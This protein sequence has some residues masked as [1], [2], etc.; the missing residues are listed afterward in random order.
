MEH[1]ARRVALEIL[2]DGLLCPADVARLAGVS[3]QA[4]NNWLRRS[5]I[6]WRTAYE[7]RA[8]LLWRK[9]LNR[10][11]IQLGKS[12]GP[13]FVEPGATRRH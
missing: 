3:L 7:T 12:S 9:R 8:T 4:V 11:A 6:D 5:G 2:R 13:R 10:G 1:L